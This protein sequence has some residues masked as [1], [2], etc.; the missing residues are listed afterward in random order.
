MSFQVIFFD[1]GETILHPHP[2]F[3]ELLSIVLAEHGH[4]GIEPEDV[5]ARSKVVSERFFAAARAGQTWSTSPEVSREFWGGLYRELLGE[6]GLPWTTELG[7]ALYATFTDV[8]H[9]RLFSEVE[10]SLEALASD[11]YELGLISNFE[12]WLELLL[13][14][15]GVTRFFEVRVISG[16]EGVEKP[17]PAIFRLALERAG[18][19]ASDAVYVG[20]SLEFDV[21]PAT[22]LGMLG[23]LLDRR[24][25]YPDAACPRIGS[26][27]ELAGL[28]ARTEAPA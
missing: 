26:L 10:D 7:E 27:A 25:R 1:A 12:E 23:V 3:P 14:H 4:D 5:R 13:E 16:V 24:D 15:L 22:A 21:E 18:V 11:G 8:S 2:S 19:E 20:D 6:M 28:L 17:D 9:Y